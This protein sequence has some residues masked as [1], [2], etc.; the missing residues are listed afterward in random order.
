M[1]SRQLL[2]TTAILFALALGLSAYVWQLRRRE[3]QSPHSLAATLP[4]APPA[5]GPIERVT[6]WVAHDDTGT[7]RPETASVPLTSGRQQQAEAL[8]RVLLDI[9]TAKGSPHLLAPGSEVRAVYLVDPGV[10]VIDVNGTLAS[11]HVSGVLAEDLTTASLIETLSANIPDLLRVKIL[12][13]GKEGNTLAGH[14]DISNFYDVTE[15]NEL[16]MQL[17]A[18]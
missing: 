3:A 6:I 1:I 7:L 11:G 13:D 14:A 15:V 2:V 10:A 17:A 4:L 9:Y 8:M 18:E 16:A 5:T 12:V